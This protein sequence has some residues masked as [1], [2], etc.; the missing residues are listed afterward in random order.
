[1]YDYNSDIVMVSG[2]TP[3]SVPW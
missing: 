3:P 1:M 2:S